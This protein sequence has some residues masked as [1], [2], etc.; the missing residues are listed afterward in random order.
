M[1]KKIIAIL[2]VLVF[3]LTACDSNE[4]LIKG[5]PTKKSG[6]NDSSVRLIENFN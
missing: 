4:D 2:S 5:G 6:I 1:K 3:L